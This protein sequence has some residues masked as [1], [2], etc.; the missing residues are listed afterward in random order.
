[1]WCSVGALI[2]NLVA[3]MLLIPSYGIIGAAMSTTIAYASWLLL[4]RLAAMKYHGPTFP[5]GTLLRVIIASLA[6]TAVMVG[7]LQYGLD[8]NFFVIMVSIFLGMIAYSVTLY[9][10]GE[11]TYKEVQTVLT[12]ISRRLRKV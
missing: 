9:L 11:F 12:I 10:L 6:T 8:N 1:M 7:I 4:V 3:C 2:V 5:W